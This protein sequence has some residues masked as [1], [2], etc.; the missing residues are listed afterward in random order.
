MEFVSTCVLNINGE[1]EENFTEFTKKSVEYYKQVAL[2]NKTG[3]MKKTPRY[4]FSLHYVRPATGERDWS[5]VVNATFSYTDD[6]GQKWMYTGVYR[7]STGDEKT[8]GDNPAGYD[9][10]FGAEKLIKE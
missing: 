4:T 10:D 8:D 3:H 2:M 6:A 7:L 5:T 9:V 1:Q